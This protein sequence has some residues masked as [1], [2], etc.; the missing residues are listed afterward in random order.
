MGSLYR[1]FIDK[2]PGKS[3]SHNPLGSNGGLG[4][5]SATPMVNSGLQIPFFF[6]FLKKKKIKII[7]FLKKI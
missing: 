6:L 2:S 5:V 4:V 3:L 7:F 1:I